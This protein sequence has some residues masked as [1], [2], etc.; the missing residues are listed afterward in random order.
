VFSIRDN[1]DT[2]KVL[3][4]QLSGLTTATTRTL[5]V[6]DADD[7]IVV[8][9]ASQTLTNK[10]LTS[11]TIRLLAGTDAIKVP[12]G[13]TAQRPGSPNAGDVRYNSDDS[14][15]E[16]YNGSWTQP[17][18]GTV[19]SITAGTALSGGTITTSG[20]I[21]LDINGL[22]GMTDGA[23]ASDYLV[24]YD[25]SGAVTRKVLPNHLATTGYSNQQYFAEATLTDQATIAWDVSTSQVAKVTL[26]GNRTMGAPTNLKAGGT[27]VLRVI[28]DGTGSRTITWNAVFKWPAATAPT[29]TTTASAVDIFT[30]VSDGTNLY[31][32]GKALNVS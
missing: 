24:M 12:V 4:L 2:T 28:Q 27:Y 25:T 18:A 19:T 3:Q 7:T 1:L 11:P 5:T 15:L 14:K 10:T 16:Y 30:F 13:T 29:L 26:G 23:A 31:M 21:A 8:L 17:G 9:A 22:T 32:I 20:T 6:P